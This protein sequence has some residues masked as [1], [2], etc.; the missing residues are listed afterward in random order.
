MKKVLLKISQNSQENTS[1]GAS[2]LIKSQACATLLKKD[3]DA[4]VFL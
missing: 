3:S 2:V 4:G 1:V